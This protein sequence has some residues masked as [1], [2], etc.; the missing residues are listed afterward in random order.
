[1]IFTETPLRGAYVIEPELL[2]DSRGF[3]ARTW[4]QHEFAQHKLNSRLVQCSTSFNKYRGTLRGM[5]YQTAPHEEAKLV[6]CTAG[7]IFD[8]IID[9]RPDSPM[10]KQHMTAVLSEE[11]HKMLY[12]PEGFAHGFLTLADN[13]EIFY[14]MSE[15]YSPECSRGVRWN[16]PA[17]GIQWLFTPSIVSDRDRSYPDFIPSSLAAHCSRLTAP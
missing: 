1:M 6:R 4:C 11:N 2:A 8:V 14:Q 16:D 9:L 17:F 15:F 10:F 3:F 5:H 13:S 7:A 12:I